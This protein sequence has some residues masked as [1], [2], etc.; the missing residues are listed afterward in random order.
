MTAQGVVLSAGFLTLLLLPASAL[1]GR[2]TA[3]LFALAIAAT[4][5][6]FSSSPLE[7]AASD[8][9]AQVGNA[10]SPQASS[11]LRVRG[12]YL[13]RVT[14][15]GAC[16]AADAAGGA[17]LNWHIFGTVWAGNLTPAPAGLGAWSDAEVLRFL[18]SGVR[19]DGSA[20]HWRS[21]A[22][23]HS[24]NFS[25]ED[26]RALLAYLRDLPAVQRRVPAARPPQEGDSE[27]FVVWPHALDR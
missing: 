8:P 19:R 21:A 14:A 24:A 17:K 26:R 6:F 25:V 5:W 2:V 22:W 7:P 20:A 1:R 18:A 11:R 27:A 4:V 9:G 23:A 10:L 12:K 16:H 15:C 3:A 13:Y